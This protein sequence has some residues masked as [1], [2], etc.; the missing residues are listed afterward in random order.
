MGKKA[1]DK[2]AQQLRLV[3]QLTKP[4]PE[5]WQKPVLSPGQSAAMRKQQLVLSSEQSAALRKWWAK[6][7]EEADRQK[8][9]GHILDQAAAIRDGMIPQPW[10]KLHPPG[11]KQRKP[12]RKSK[13]KRGA[14]FKLTPDEA[15]RG[16]KMIR[17]EKKSD[18]R[19]TMDAAEA[20]LRDRLRHN[21]GSPITV[22]FE[23]WRKRIIR[24]AFRKT[25]RK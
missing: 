12:E 15:K 20:I 1:D 19:L 24:P 10:A 9:A 22:G 18:R 7:R 13:T 14:P 11:L 4:P 25:P 17:D 3:R 2:L 6:Q 23:T 8:R 21:D 16:I 5:P